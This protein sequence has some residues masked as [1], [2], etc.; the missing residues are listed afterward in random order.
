MPGRRKPRD[1][2]APLDRERTL[3]LSV[4]RTI[5]ATPHELFDAWTDPAQL[6]QWWGPAEVTCS[7]AEVDLRVGGRYRLA[8]LFPDGRLVW[9]SGE[10][11]RIERP[12]LLVYGWRIEPAELRELVT[13]RF[14]ANGGKTDVVVLHE[15]IV[16][17]TARTQHELGWIGCLEKLAARYPF[18]RRTTSR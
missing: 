18:S 10:F 5:D 2:S 7:E 1:A 6:R 15:G 16:D 12:H 3:A 9:I 14:I 4:R 17:L 8:N 11:V 13:V